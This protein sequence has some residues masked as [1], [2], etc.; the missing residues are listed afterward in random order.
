MKCTKNYRAA[1]KQITSLPND[2]LTIVDGA[3]GSAVSV[4]ALFQTTQLA[5]NDANLAETAANRAL[6]RAPDINRF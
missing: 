5:E 3:L 4:D 6:L 2:S 1:A